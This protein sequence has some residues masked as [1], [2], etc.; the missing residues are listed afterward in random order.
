MKKIIL[1]SFFMMLCIIAFSQSTFEIK[2]I[3]DQYSSEQIVAVFNSADFCG[4]Y[5]ETKRNLITLNDGSEIELKSGRE[6]IDSEV[7][8]APSCLLTDDTIYF[9][10]TWSISPEGYLMKGFDNTLYPTEKEYYRNNNI[11]KQ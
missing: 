7:N 11:N 5:F 2:K 4:S 6:L 9:I 3:G 1:S 10:S 8:I